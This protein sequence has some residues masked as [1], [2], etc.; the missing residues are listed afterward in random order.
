MHDS[1]ADSPAHPAPSSAFYTAIW[2]VLVLLTAL[3]VGVTYLDLKKLTLI[4]AVLIATVKATLVLM[5][6]MH[7]RYESRLFTI[8]LLVGLGAFA[9]FISLTFSDLSF[10]FY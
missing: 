2:L 5:Y 6:F 10:R 9:V 1:Q 8:M 7:L 4:A 3:T